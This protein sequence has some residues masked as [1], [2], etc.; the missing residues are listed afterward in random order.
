MIKS[1]S[2][3]LECDDDQKH[4]LKLG[5]RGR[6]AQVNEAFPLRHQL[7]N[8]W[9]HDPMVGVAG[10]T[11]CTRL[12]PLTPRRRRCFAAVRLYPMPSHNAHPEHIVS[13]ADAMSRR[14][15]YHSGTLVEESASALGLSAGGRR[16]SERLDLSA[17]VTRRVRVAA[18]NRWTELVFSPSCGRA[19]LLST[20]RVGLWHDRRDGVRRR[21]RTGGVER[22]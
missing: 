21:R 14:A 17:E 9:T 3:G 6:E 8:F 1:A 19:P 16:V 10:V 15:A 5:V 4:A 2:L 18:T 11:N 22:R 20:V 13:P 7:S 12:S